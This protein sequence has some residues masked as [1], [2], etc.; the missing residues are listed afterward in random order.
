MSIE[1][2]HELQRLEKGEVAHPA[3][4][5]LLSWQV[6]ALTEDEPQKVEAWFMFESEFG[7]VHLSRQFGVD[8]PDMLT[9]SVEIFV[10]PENGGEGISVIELEY[11]S[12]KTFRTRPNKDVEDPVA[13]T[14]KVID[15]IKS[16]CQISGQEAG[17]LDSLGALVEAIVLMNEDDLPED[18]IVDFGCVLAETINRRADVHTLSSEYNFSDDDVE[19]R[20]M[21][22]RYVDTSFMRPELTDGQGEFEILITDKNTRTATLVSGGHD[23]EVHISEKFDVEIGAVDYRHATS[24]DEQDITKTLAALLRPTLDDRTVEWLSWYSDYLGWSIHQEGPE[25][26][27]GIEMGVEL[28]HVRNLLVQRLEEPNHFIPGYSKGGEVQDIE[29][30]FADNNY[31]PNGF[32]ITTTELIDFSTMIVRKFEEAKSRNAIYLGT[33]FLQPGTVLKGIIASYGA[34]IDVVMVTG[35]NKPDKSKITGSV[36]LNESE[37]TGS[38]R[39]FN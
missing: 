9:Q 3:T 5:N 28:N 36:V 29:L 6:G 2:D 1:W 24:K 37:I 34:Y 4:A 35:S 7:S 13:T 39:T 15:T 31:H 21:V 10:A 20:A 30:F 26:D 17:M 23:Q 22:L 19:L 33:K 11:T 12:Q 16:A 18:L 27:Y 8:E 25:T 38:N 32:A 14:L